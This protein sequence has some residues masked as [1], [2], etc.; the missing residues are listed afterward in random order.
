MHDEQVRSQ[1]IWLLLQENEMADGSKFQLNSP[2]PTTPQV[3][4]MLQIQN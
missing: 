1:S 4:V 3:L 2:T